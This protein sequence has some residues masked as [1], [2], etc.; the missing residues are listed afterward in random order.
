MAFRASFLPAFSSMP[1]TAL[2]IAESVDM[3]RLLE[4]GVRICGV[5]AGYVTI[6]VDRPSD[7]ELVEALLRQDPAQR[8]LDEQIRYTGSNQ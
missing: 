8:A 2:E 1:E 3:L 5:V 4:H 6:G 7:V